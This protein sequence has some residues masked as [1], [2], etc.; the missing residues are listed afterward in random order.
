[1][2]KIN[3]NETTGIYHASHRRDDCRTP[4]GHRASSAEGLSLGTLAPGAPLDEKNPLAAILLKALEQHGY[5][6]GKN[7]NDALD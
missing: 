1:L 5:T 6:L 7:L 2:G 3:E 4:C